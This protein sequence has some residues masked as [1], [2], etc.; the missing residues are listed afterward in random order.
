MLDP[1]TLVAGP[2]FNALIAHQVMKWE[3]VRYHRDATSTPY[4]LDRFG[5]L[6]VVDLVQIAREQPFAPSTNISAAW[7]VIEK[8]DG[9]FTIYGPNATYA[10]A[11][12]TNSPDWRAEYEGQTSYAD[13]APLAICR[14]ALKVVTGFYP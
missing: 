6:Y 5:S 13:S 3:V 12:Y 1:D 11:E 9:K 4:V 8:L 10:H 14:V 7:L 2:E